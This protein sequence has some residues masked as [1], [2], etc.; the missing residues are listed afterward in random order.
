M[1]DD[2]IEG[3]TNITGADEAAGAAL[4]QAM[5]ASNALTY[6]VGG[7]LLQN[8][9]AR[10][11]KADPNRVMHALP[12][13]KTAT[14]DP[15]AHGER[16]LVSWYFENKERL[17]LPEPHE[18]TVITSLDPCTM[19]A[20]ALLTA[21][22]HVGVGAY[23]IWSGINYQTNCDFTTLPDNLAQQAK[24]HF[25]YY[26]AGVETT[27]PAMYVRDYRGSPS[28]IF[29]DGR[30]SARTYMGCGAIFNAGL[31]A[32][33]KAK[34]NDGGN[35]NTLEDP[36]FLPEDS[37]IKQIY[38]DIYPEAFQLK[39]PG[40]QETRTPDATILAELERVAGAN[41]HAN[42]VAFIDP[43]G[44][45]VLCLAEETGIETAF[46]RVTRAYAERRF[47]LRQ[48]DPDYPPEDR[49]TTYLTQPSYGAFVYLRAPDPREARTIMSFGAYGSSMAGAIPPGYERNFL[50]Y[51]LPDG[52][53]QEDLDKTIANL[54]PFYNQTVRMTLVQ[55]AG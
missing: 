48:G 45:L 15:T 50:Y 18:L 44:N 43:F 6:P 9:T 10:V 46:M 3:E 39:V 19:C 42:A 14:R 37:R 51:Q 1:R 26:R 21:G 8:S 32:V 25:G 16:Q 2:I 23:D 40:W 41:P 22:F 33:Q 11:L 49:S 52:V 31:T 53:T 55:V 47:A 7:V 54:P 20:G 30:M 13:G 4:D 35:P 29:R 38:R 27:D 36:Y 5:V 17:Q 28:L 34:G 12:G 24:E